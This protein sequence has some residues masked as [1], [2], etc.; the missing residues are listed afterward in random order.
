[1][2]VDP[3]L[4]G[5]ERYFEKAQDNRQIRNLMRKEPD[6]A[7]SLVFSVPGGRVARVYRTYGFVAT[8]L[9]EGIKKRTNPSEA[10][11]HSGILRI[12]GN[13]DFDMTL[14]GLDDRKYHFLEVRIQEIRLLLKTVYLHKR[15]DGDTI[16]IR[17]ILKRVQLLTVTSM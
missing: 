5:I 11:G 7:R 1:M 17:I 13:K 6:Y 14:K 2:G 4:T 8:K 9:D 10:E 15:R 3:Y 12:S 16:R